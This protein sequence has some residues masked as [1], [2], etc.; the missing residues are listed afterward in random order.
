MHELSIAQNIV[1]IVLHHLPEG[2][3]GVVR[4]VRVRVG[5]LSGIV[6]KSLDFCFSSIVGDTPLRGARLDIE[7]VPV[8][9]RCLACEK[10]FSKED[11]SVYICPVCGSRDL[12]FIKGTELEV[13]EIALEDE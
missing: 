10:T 3:N 5:L 4:S 13:V 9:A 7:D 1:D 8:E 2:S 11:V 6:P 12:H